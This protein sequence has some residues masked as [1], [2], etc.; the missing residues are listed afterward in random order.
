MDDSLKHSPSVLP[1]LKKIPLF[2]TF[3]EEEYADI[4]RN[5]RLEYFPANYVLFRKGS[6]GDSMFIIKNG[7]IQIYLEKESKIKEIALL[8]GSE[9]FGE[10]SLFAEESRNASARTL[11]ESE[12]FV[13]KKA[14][15]KK[16]LLKNQNLASKVSKEFLQRVNQNNQSVTPN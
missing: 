14:D 9:F 1:I 12:V 15:F 8:K 4:I 11:Q 5:I 3:T 10:M 16:L 2:S 7:Q 13:L 6:D